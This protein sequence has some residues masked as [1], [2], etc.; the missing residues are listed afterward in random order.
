MDTDRRSWESGFQHLQQYIRAEGNPLVPQT[1]K[2][3]DGFNLGSWVNTERARYNRKKLE[4]DR[5]ERLAEP[6]GRRAWSASEA[7]W[8]EG[9]QYLRQFAETRGHVTVPIDYEVDGF[10]LRDWLA[11]NRVKFDKL[12][13]DRQHRLKS[14]P[15]WDG[16]S[17]T[18]KWEEGY[19][20][21]LNYVAENGTAAVRAL[22]Q[23]RG[24]SSRRVGHDKEAGSQTRNL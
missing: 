7:E 18:A 22:I 16:Y 24:V 5:A 11:N 12:S 23:G 15:G 9:F 4:P 3:V 17:H 2:T 1:Y 6:G 8:D 10:K 14:L 20:R 13:P 21:L 19:R